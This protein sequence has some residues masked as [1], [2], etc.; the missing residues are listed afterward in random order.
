[1]VF[2]KLVSIIVIAQLFS[3]HGLFL[4]VAHADENVLTVMPDSISNIYSDIDMQMR[5]AAKANLAPCIVNCNDY[6]AFSKRITLLGEQLSATA[7]LINPALQ[8][9]IPSFTFNVIDKK[10]LG[11]ASNGG[12]K[13]VIFRGLQQLQLTDNALSFIIAREMGHVIG[14]HHTKNTSTKLI[15]TA[16]ASVLFPAFAVIGASSAAAQAT[17][18]TLLTS[19][20]STATSMFGSEVALAKMKP[21]QL[22]ESDNIAIDLLNHQDWD[23]R[24]VASILQLDENAELINGQNGWIKDLQVS[25]N[26]LQKML[27]KE[28]AETIPIEDDHL[29]MD[30]NI[31]TTHLDNTAEPAQ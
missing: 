18:T 10:D 27:E 11:T 25:D 29:L 8:K 13:V 3:S 14:R 20:A 26:Y 21:S 16:L 31:I 28:D 15:I 12:G 19:A 17:T 4:S 6:Q 9:R 1:M 22:V 23:M 5:L 2:K 7:F 24:S 30:E